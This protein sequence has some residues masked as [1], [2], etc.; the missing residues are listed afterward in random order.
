M[1]RAF[2]VKVTAS[3]E[4]LLY[5]VAQIVGVDIDIWQYK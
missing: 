2:A 5:I 3:P 1:L 4:L